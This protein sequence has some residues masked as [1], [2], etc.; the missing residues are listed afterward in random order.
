MR[1]DLDP[2]GD[3]LATVVYP[4]QDELGNVAYLTGPDGVVLE[5]YDYETYGRFR[6]FAPDGTPRSASSLGWN[7]LFQGREYVPALEAYDFRNRHLLP[8]LG[9]FAQEDPLGYVD[10]LNLY[11]AFGGGWVNATDPWG[12]AVGG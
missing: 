8:A 4:V 9:R 3:G 7:R 5:R 2:D 12:L 10:S 1:A 11:Q 6:V